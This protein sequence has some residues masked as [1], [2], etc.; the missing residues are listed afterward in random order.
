MTKKLFAIITITLTFLFSNALADDDKR[1]GSYLNLSATEGKEVQE[2]LL[3]ATLYFE[4]EGSSPQSVQKKINETMAK[5]LDEIK[6]NRKVKASTRNYSVYKYQPLV[7]KGE[8]KKSIWKGSQSIQLNSKDSDATLKTASTLQSMGLAQSGLSYMVS[9]ELREETKDSLTEKAIEKL[10]SKAKKIAKML[11]K[12]EIDVVSINVDSNN[13]YPTPSS[14]AS[15]MKTRNIT[16]IP[17]VAS[18]GQTR[19]ST[20]ISATILIKD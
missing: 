3:I 18:P 1:K 6:R 10:M 14:S 11:G 2:D 19:V 13:Y 17:I 8:K 20:T 5:A 7:K 9:P 15:M 12:E 4:A 16:E